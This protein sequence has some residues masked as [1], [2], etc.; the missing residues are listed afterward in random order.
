MKILHLTYDFPD[1]I[2]PDKTSAIKNITEL[3]R[4]DGDCCI[5]LNRTTRFGRTAVKRCDNVYALQTFGLP[6]GILFIHT[7]DRSINAVLSVGLDFGSFDLVHAHKLSFEGPI[8]FHLHNLYG[9]PCIITIQQTDFKILKYKPLLRNYYYR[10][11]EAAQHI[12]LIS[13]WMEKQLDRVFG[14]KRM[15]TLRDKLINI[16]LAVERECIS[17]PHDNGRFLCVFNMRHGYIRLKNIYRVLRAIRLLKEAGTAIAMDIVGDGAASGLVENMIKK[18][19]V[20]DRV[21]MTGRVENSRIVE[22]MSD[23]RAFVLCSYPE[24]FGM[25]YIEALSAGLPLIHSKDAGI[26]GFFDNMGI[27]IAVRHDSIGEICR[28]FCEI[29]KN[30][31][32]FRE[33]VQGLQNSG[34]LRQFSDESVR[35]KYVSIY[36]SVVEQ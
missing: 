18:L 30:A 20:E 4:G 1:V 23:Y 15:D 14:F 10:I 27:G 31:G 13:P 32:R 35:E 21:V 7:L 29:D 3:T 12:V 9:L 5:S 6:K 24:T 8:A 34:V 2:N 28:A 33:N 17:K 36:G 19:G 22:F 11:L 25:V 16:P 26:D